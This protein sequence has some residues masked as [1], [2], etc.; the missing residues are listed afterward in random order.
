MSIREK[1]PQL[2]ELFDK[3]IPVYSISKLDSINNCLYGA[4]KTY[5]LHE[6]SADNIYSSLGSRMHDTLEAITNGEATEADLLPAMYSELEDA[7]MLGLEFPKDSKGGSSIKDGW[8]ANMEHFCKTYKAPVGNFKT[9]QFFLYK[10]P[11]GRYLQGYIDLQRIRKDGSVDIYDY[12]TSTKYT[13][14]GMKDHGRQLLVYMLGIQ[15][16]GIK[17]NS[18][19]WIFLKYASVSFMGKKTSKSKEKTLIEKVVERRKIGS[20]LAKYIDSDLAELGYEKFERDLILDDFIETNEIPKEVSDNYKVR[21]YVCKYEIT[22]ENIAECIKYIDSTIDMW[23]SLNSESDSDYPPLEFEKVTK[24]GKVIPNTFFC[25]S[26]C[27]YGKS[28]KY[29]AEY[30]ELFK[31][32]EDD[33]FDI[34]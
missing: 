11:K 23:E 26:L 31:T 29:I 8:V 10:T 27:G 34:F 15:Q 24:T 6:K 19:S 14:E 1:N 33:D 20:E 21:P 16:Q 7:E 18:V 32:K 28:C 25:N 5:I 2:Q 17:V 3:G 30:N 22:D 4:Y 12:K 13:K 9:E